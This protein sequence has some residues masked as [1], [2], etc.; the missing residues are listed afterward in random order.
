M[1]RCPSDP[2]FRWGLAMVRTNLSRHYSQRQEWD[3]A[4]EIIRPAAVDFSY[5]IRTR[6]ELMGNSSFVDHT[7]ECL[8]QFK[9][10]LDQTNNQEEAVAF[11]D[12]VLRNLEP[13]RPNSQ[14][15]FQAV[16]K[17]RKARPQ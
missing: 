13:L 16:Q 5:L 1:A 15:L 10:S 6:R 11:L 14:V 12:T 7:R 17:L 3:S 4:A 2:D 9:V 8:R